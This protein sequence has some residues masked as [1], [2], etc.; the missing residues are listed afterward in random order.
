MLEYILSVSYHLNTAT[1]SAAQ[2]MVT[3]TGP[4]FV[5]PFKTQNDNYSCS[6]QGASLMRIELTIVS[7][8]ACGGQLA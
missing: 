8:C 7:A 6:H 5:L 4:L 2:L 1:L 3:V